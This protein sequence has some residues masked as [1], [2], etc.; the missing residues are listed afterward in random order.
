[1]FLVAHDCSLKA[2][3]ISKHR[4]GIYYIYPHIV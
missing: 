2:K 4:Y 3:L 1:M